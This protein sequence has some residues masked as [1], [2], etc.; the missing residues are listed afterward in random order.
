MRYDVEYDDGGHLFIASVDE[1]WDKEAEASGHAELLS[2]HIIGSKLDQYIKDDATLIWMSAL[3]DLALVRK[4]PMRRE[5][6][7]DTPTEKR[8]FDLQVTPVDERRVQL[9]HSLLSCNPMLNRVNIMYSGA[10]VYS[11]SKRCSI[12]NSVKIKDRWVDPFD[13]GQDQN[14]NVSHE[15][16]GR[17]LKSESAYFVREMIAE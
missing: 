6:R 4:S 17:C 16:C 10:A 7:C 2:R 11:S 8:V 14:L 12:C 1:A 15:I 3:V 13:L 9:C 5:Y